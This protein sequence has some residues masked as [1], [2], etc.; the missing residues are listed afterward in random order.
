MKSA[1]RGFTLIE[2][3]VVISII[4]LLSQSYWPPFPAPETRD[5]I[6]SAILFADHNYQAFGA[7]A[8]AYWNFNEGNGNSPVMNKDGHSPQGAFPVL[9]QSGHGITLIP[10]S[11]GRTISRSNI[12]PTGSGYSIDFSGKPNQVLQT[13]NL[14]AL[15]LRP[16]ALTISMW[17]YITDT[18]NLQAG[19]LINISN[20]QT[21]EQI[22]FTS[23]SGTGYLQC[24][25]LFGSTCDDGNNGSQ[26]YIKLIQGKWQHIAISFHPGASNSTVT[27]YV[28]G[29]QIA[30]DPSEGGLIGNDWYDEF[31]PIQSITIG[32][33]QP[34]VEMYLDDVA[35][36]SQA[37]SSD[38]IREIY[39]R[40]APQHEY[41]ANVK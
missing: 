10:F 33:M 32:Q 34:T 3:L 35:I 23:T 36:Y 15:N 19:N 11:S 8:V 9:D 5:G 40:E 7:D 16:M 1:S 20:S 26:T 14:S 4:G 13:L 41:A 38:Q 25:I 22:S 27:F 28:D 17:L 2:L 39:A 6:A 29:K 31:G 30:K 18:V 24:D 21:I 12:T 37:L